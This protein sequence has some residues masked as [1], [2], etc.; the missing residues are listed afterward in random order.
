MTAVL[1]FVNA[2]AQLGLESLLIKPK[3]SIGIFIPQVVFEEN[4]YDELEITEHPIEQ[5]AVIADHAYKRPAEVTIHCGWSNSPSKSSLLSAALGAASALSPVVQQVGQAVALVGAAQGI[6][7]GSQSGYQDGGIKDI[8]AKLRDYQ[9]ARLLFDVYT[10]KLKYENMLIRTLTQE[11]DKKSE[12]SLML[13][14]VC[15][16]V[17]LATT[18]LAA[19]SSVAAD[20]TQIAGSGKN[21][22]PATKQLGTKTVTPVKSFNNKLP[23]PTG[24]NGGTWTGSEGRIGGLG[25][26]GASGSW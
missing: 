16:Q 13:T 10:G 15:C 5:G 20:Q 19:P 18:E 3:R 17:L 26:S 25:G 7:E 12:N 23:S 1:G 11:T 4:H 14:I 24:A 22:A 6:L 9:M 2:A 8:Y 21:P